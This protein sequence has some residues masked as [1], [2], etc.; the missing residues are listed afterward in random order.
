MSEPVAG[1]HVTGAAG[2]PDDLDNAYILTAAQARAAGL[3]EIGDLEGVGVPLVIGAN[4]EF[5][6]RPYGPEGALATYGVT[7][8]VYPIEDYG[9]PLTVG[10]LLDGTVNVADIY[11][12]SPSIAENDLVTLADPENLILPQQVVPIVSERVDATAAAAIDSASALLDTATLIELNTLSTVQQQ[13]SAQ[14][15]R[16]W[17]ASVGLGG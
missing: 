8:E 1:G 2:L 12:A 6:A 16:D 15:A 13:S 14:I 10:A 3:M 7:I 5:D 11:T 4:S 9:G 17:L